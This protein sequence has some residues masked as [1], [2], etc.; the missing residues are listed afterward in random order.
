VC[1]IIIQALLFN[2][3]LRSDNVILRQMKKEDKRDR[4]V[5]YDL[6]LHGLV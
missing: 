5:C 3:A 1:V 4:W 6:K 2:Y